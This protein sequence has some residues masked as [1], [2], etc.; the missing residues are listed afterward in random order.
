[1]KR[2]ELA[3]GIQHYLG[4]PLLK[5]ARQP[6]QFTMEQAK[7]YAKC[8]RDP[9]YFI[10][11]Y[12]R[13]VS[14]DEGL[15][16]FKMYPYQKRMIRA[17]HHGRKVVGKIFRQAG[18][19]AICAAYI[20]WYITFNGHKTAAILANKASIAREIFSRI[21][22]ILENLPF[23]L[24]QG[25]LE[26][27]KTSL[28]LENGSKCFCAASSPSSVRGKS[29]NLLFCVAGETKVHLRNKLTGEIVEVPISDLKGLLR[30]E[31]EDDEG[32]SISLN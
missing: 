21:Q 32:F 14:L 12:V 15:V 18:K 13:I 8:A 11:N 7:E 3:E 10:E 4:N 25:V 9:V 30:R 22:V 16:L 2:N 19:S 28:E 17:M 29:I 5:A 23:W 27:N 26:W 6:L 24:Q 20:S 31:E 1:M